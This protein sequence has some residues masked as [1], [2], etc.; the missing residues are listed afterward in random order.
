MFTY[1]NYKINHDNLE[2]GFLKSKLL[3]LVSWIG[4]TILSLIFLH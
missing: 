3:V 4:T 1:E 2:E